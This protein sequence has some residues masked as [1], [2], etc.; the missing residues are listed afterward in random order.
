MKLKFCGAARCVTGS[1]HMLSFD[2]GKILVDCGMRQGADE[3][4]EL[5]AAGL[6]FD[7]A[8]ISAVLLTHAHI[9]HSGLLPL[10]VKRGFTGQIITTKA[11]AELSGIMLPDSAHIQEQDAE[12]QNRKNL[13]AGKAMIEPLYTM[14]DAQAALEKFRAVSYG[15]IVQIMPG[16]RA[17]FN[18]VGHLLGSAAIE[19][20]VEEKNTTTKIVFSGD[21]GRA[22]RPILRD[23]AIIESA[24]YVIMEGT[25]GDR[26]HDATTE[27][28]KEAQLAAVLKEGISRGG[29]IVIPSFAVGRTQELIYSIKRLIMKNAV[30]GLDKV[31]IFVDSPLGINATKVYERCAQ[32]YYD[33]EASAMLKQSGSPFDLDNLRVAETSEESKLINFQNGCNIIISASG[34]CDAGRIRHHLKHNLYRPDSTI[35]FAG[36]QANGTLGRILLNGVK[37][38]KLFGEQIHVNAAIR[39]IDGFSG[40]AGRSELLHWLG[41]M[42]KAPKCVFLVHGESA[43]LDNFIGAVRAL[44]VDAEI[45]E[46][47]D[48]YELTYGQSGLVRMPAL[49]AQKAT[50]PDLFIGRRLNIIAKQWGI[51][52]ALYCLRGSEPL[53]DTAIGVADARKQDLNGIHTRFAAGDITML[54]TAAAALKL[55]MQGKLDIDAPLNEYAAQYAK[56]NAVTARELLL[57]QKAVPDYADNCLNFKLFKQAKEQKLNAAQA[58]ELRWNTLNGKINDEQ[59]L[60]IMNGLAL[61]DDP[62]NYAGLKGSY[63]VLGM[64][65]AKASGMNLAKALEELIFAPLGMKDTAFGGTAEVTYTLPV[66]DERITLAAPVNIGGEAG[67][68]TSAYDLAHFGAALMA[69]ELLDE[70]HMDIMFAPGACAMKAANGWYYA[71]SG[72]EGTQSCLY[73]NAQY[74]VSAAVLTNA[75]CAFAGQDETGAVSFAQRM[76]YEMDDVYIRAED[77]QLEA[78]NDS[79]VYSVLKLAVNEDQQELVAGNDFSLAQAAALEGALPYAVTQNGVAVG[80][81]MLNVDAQR[82]IFEIWRLMIDK[83]FQRKGFGKAAMRLAMAELER[84]GASKAQLVVDPDNEAAVALYQGLGFSFTGRMEQG[85]AYMECEF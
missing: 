77:V 66:G 26:E 49:T 27:E 10:L 30:E 81:A 34:M 84:M 3:K 71:D 22:Q 35:L 72:L 75:P 60:G 39:Q 2:G 48:E 73:L 15:D 12:Y 18:D 64:A 69:G 80:F 53:Y 50:E 79:N 56:A 23:P 54:F 31:K 33:E 52:G 83:R 24:D 20:W 41:S 74:G 8:E 11:T 42:S 59:A 45:P 44:G 6:A 16:L 36:Y 38:V 29:N 28:E 1:C 40:H 58:L 21:I 61:I 46:L 85:E 55:N 67:A 51:N 14:A 62:D 5:G 70:D 7:P 32:E 25:Y 78:V 68:V 57:G 17:R 43:T 47:F 82:G 76:R 63:R 65:V 19:L 37:S 4:G 9:D 13:R